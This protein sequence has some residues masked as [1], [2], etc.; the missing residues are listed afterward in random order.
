MKIFQLLPS[1][2]MVN[3]LD[4]DFLEAWKPNVPLLNYKQTQYFT[5]QIAELK[6]TVYTDKA[7]LSIL[8][9]NV[10][11]IATFAWLHVVVSHVRQ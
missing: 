9:S 4:V 10:V 5:P 6:E 11:T 3:K 8:A 1:T 7:P 2:M